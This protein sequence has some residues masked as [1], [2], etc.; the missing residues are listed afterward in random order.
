MFNS[1]QSRRRIAAVGLI[2]AMVIG[3]VAAN[4]ARIAENPASGATGRLVGFGP[5]ALGAVRFELAKVGTPQFKAPDGLARHALSSAPLNSDT[6]AALAA[7]SMANQ[8]RAST[9]REIALLSEAI[10]RNPRSR[11]ARI[12]MIRAQAVRG[13]VKQAFAQLAVLARLNPDIAERLMDALTSR[14]GTVR[15][16]DQA[17]EALKG[18]DILYQP[19]IN[20]MIGKSKSRDVVL[21]LTAL[22]PAHIKAR[23]DIRSSLVRLLVETGEVSVAKSIWLLGVDGSR[24]QL[25]YSPDFGDRRSRPPFNW[26]LLVGPTGAAERIE[27]GGIAVTYYDRS[28]G[29]LATQLLTLRAGMYQVRVDYEVIDGDAENV[30]VRIMCSPSGTVLAEVPLARTK[31]GVITL[32]VPFAVPSSGCSAQ[33]GAIVGV[34]GGK[35]GQMQLNVKRFDILRQGSM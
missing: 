21:R 32:S 27:R 19:F 20:R 33:L 8:N 9:P 35:R 18:N 29:S 25:L 1:S 10:R 13:D 30:R 11:S 34:A 23:P 6:F 12:L 24:D 14:I 3:V 4:L 15:Q 22:V 7:A 28:S 16:V 2:L 26:E 5:G 31:P 17:M